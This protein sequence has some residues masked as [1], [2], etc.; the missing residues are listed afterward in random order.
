MPVPARPTPS[1]LVPAPHGEDPRSRREHGRAR[2]LARK[3]KLSESSSILVVLVAALTATG[4]IPVAAALQASDVLDASHAVDPTPSNSAQA[5][6]SDAAGCDPCTGHEPIVILEDEGPLGFTLGEHPKTGEPIHRP[7]SGVVAGTGTAEDPFII[8]GWAT[9]AIRIQQTS[10]HVVVRGNEVG[11]LPNPTGPLPSDTI[12]QDLI[13]GQTGLSPWEQ[14]L[15]SLHLEQVRN[16]RIETN[17]VQAS[18]YGARLIQTETIVVADNMFRDGDAGIKAEETADLLVEGNTVSDALMGIDLEQSQ[19]LGISA[20]TIAGSGEA[21]RVRDTEDVEVQDNT[22][23]ESVIGVKLY[24]AEN[25]R[26]LANDF[27]LAFD[28]IMAEK[29]IEAG[30]SRD[31]LVEGNLLEGAHT[32]VYS[33]SMQA[34]FVVH[35]NT[36]ATFVRGIQIAMSNASLV[37]GNRIDGPENLGIALLLTHNATVHGNVLDGPTPQDAARPGDPDPSM[38]VTIWGGSGHHVASNT[39]QAHERGV[40]VDNEYSQFESVNLLDPLDVLAYLEGQLSGEGGATDEEG[41]GG[42]EI[43]DNRIENNTKGIVLASDVPE[44][45]IHANNLQNNTA[46]I[47]LDAQ[48]ASGAQ[49]PIQAP[50]NWWGCPQGPDYPACDG[51]LG[52]VAL[53]S[54]LEAPNPSAGAS[55]G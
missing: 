4:M 47:G 19:A 24:A 3:T 26:I 8:E 21:I 41:A 20:N 13:E 12:V 49:E 35:D 51:V 44:L 55:T 28:G 40:H 31:V 7:G 39:I 15:A 46:G 32:A 50:T 5:A 34:P 14:S 52:P 36:V 11:G 22:L 27:A 18:T 10:R 29:A 53:P 45:L 43:V 17:E 16:V 48:D 23:R 9:E 42:H 38:G 2:H 6:A 37:E 33:A 25:A 30:N 1:K 54:W